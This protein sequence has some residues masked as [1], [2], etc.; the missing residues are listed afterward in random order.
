MAGPAHT[1]SFGDRLRALRQAAGLT[2]T[3]LAAG[4]FTKEYVSQ[5]ERG[6]ARPTPE[7][8][9]WLAER[10][11]VDPGR[12]ETG[13][14][15]GDRARVEAALAPADALARERRYAE[16]A[17]AYEQAETAAEGAGLEAAAI[18]AVARA[19]QAWAYGGDVARSRAATARGRQRAPDAAQTAALAFAD[20]LCLYATADVEAA[21]TA[22]DDALRLAERVSTPDD[23]L[24][25][26]ILGWRSRCHRR[27]RDPEAARED[28]DRSLE[29]ARGVGD[30]QLVANALFQSSLVA[31]RDGRWVLA[32]TQ[33]REARD[34]YATLGDRS[35]E[36]RILNNIAGLEHLL[37]NL[38]AA[39]AAL[40]HAHTLFAELGRPEEAAY[41]LASLAEIRLEQGEIGPA[42]NLARQVLA[43]LDGLSEHAQEAGTAHLVLGRALV[44]LGREAEGAA[45]LAA[46]EAAFEKASSASHQAE[47]WLASGDLALRQGD[48]REAAARFRR[49]ATA[50]RNSAE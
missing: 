46:A 3:A 35:S 27:L 2:Q 9:A 1:G 6:K 39:V 13:V 20:A 37:G 42:E 47:A 45:S 40:D 21:I 4:R 15:R 29:L 16:A 41:T 19:A 23:R 10:L 14:A 28:V 44:E 11:A 36:G 12:L 24:R 38:E 49:A 8:V 32:R 25:S 18:E 31:Q 17:A 22:F 34:L 5:L 30:D 26:D 50:L 7:T 43:V 33:A 48:A